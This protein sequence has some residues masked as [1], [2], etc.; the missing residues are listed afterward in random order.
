M[1]GVPGMAQGNKKAKVGWSRREFLK[2]AGVAAASIAFPEIIIACGPQS[3]GAPTA[4]IPKPRKGAS[5]RLLQWTSFV[6][7]ADAEFK[8]QAAEWGDANGVTVA[9]ETVTGDQLQPKTAAAVEAN[10]GPD[11]I[12][13]QYA[14]PQLY[15]D[16]CLD[17]SNEVNILIGKLGKPDPVNEA[18]CKV[19]GTWRAIPYTIVPNAWTYRTDDF[20]QAGVTSFPKTWDELTSAAAKLKATGKPISQTDG[21][22]YGDSLTM[23]N[24]VLWGF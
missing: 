11:I 18:Y 5:I 10:S 14:W 9:I 6:K 7:P 23:W 17:V 12:Q 16:A 19:N 20:Q 4:T 15:T 1:R 22:A 2:T 21:H 8:R 24:P 3:S 13:M